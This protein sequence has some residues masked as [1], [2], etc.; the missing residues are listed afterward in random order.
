MTDKLMVLLL[1]SSIRKCM[2]VSGRTR[3]R[4]AVFYVLPQIMSNLVRWK[5]DPSLLL[6]CYSSYCCT[7]DKEKIWKVGLLEAAIFEMRAR[8]I[9]P[10]QRARYKGKKCT[11]SH[12]LVTWAGELRAMSE[13]CEC[14]RP[15]RWCVYEAELYCGQVGAGGDP[16]SRGCWIINVMLWW[17]YGLKW[18]H[19]M[20]D[21][22]DALSR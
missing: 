16:K 6:L 19:L 11:Q 8:G 2:R 12:E 20:H 14:P 15:A 17:S 4:R 5:S 21:C 3:I 22:D 7:V 10:Q 9:L 18:W 1:Y 13:H